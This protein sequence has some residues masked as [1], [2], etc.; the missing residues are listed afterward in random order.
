MNSIF[1]T[2]KSANSPQSYVTFRRLLIEH[3][4]LTEFELLQQRNDHQELNILVDHLKVAYEDAPAEYIWQGHFYCCPICGNLQQPTIKL[5]RLLCEEERCRR[6]QTTQVERIIP[7][8]EHVLW[9]KRGLRRFVSLPGLTEVRLEQY[10]QKLGL[11][12]ELWPEFD[13]YDLRIIFPDGKIW[14]VDVKDWANPF[15]L[16]QNIKNIPAPEAEMA[17]FVFPDDRSR[18]PDFVR[19][20]RNTCNSHKSTSHAVIGGR[21]QAKFEKYFIADVKKKLNSFKGA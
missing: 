4:V 11:M 20:F 16:A 14:A 18:Q 12:V 5:D 10:L 21:V 15:L 9:L 13:A 7:A 8:R 1:N 17:Y 2:C 6:Q 19:A 3:P